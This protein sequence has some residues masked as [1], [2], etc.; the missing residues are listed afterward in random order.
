MLNEGLQIPAGDFFDKGLA[1][2]IYECQ[3]KL[4]AN[5]T[6]PQGIGTAIVP[7]LMSQILL[8]MLL[9]RKILS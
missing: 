3:K 4:N 5:I 8:K 1:C 9:A 6:A 7:M 2:I